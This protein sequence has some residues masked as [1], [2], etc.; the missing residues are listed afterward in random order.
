MS[1]QLD[2]NALCTLVVSLNK[3]IESVAI[4]NKLGRV[5]EKVS[6]PKYTFELPDDMN[7]LFL[8]QCVLQISM[9]KDFDEHFGP[10]NYHMLERQNLAMLSFPMDDYIL[11]VTT[12]NH[13][14]SISL[15][16]KIVNILNEHKKTSSSHFIGQ[17][18]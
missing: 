18:R 1:L 6:R 12:K 10:I 5:V 13:I 7:E 4:I 2:M 8:M 17:E 16:R 9:G 11:L 15:A 3:N 14:S